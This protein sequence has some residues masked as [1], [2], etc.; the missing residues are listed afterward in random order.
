MAS[1]SGNSLALIKRSLRALAAGPSNDSIKLLS[2][3]D[4]GNPADID[5]LD[6]RMVSEVKVGKGGGAEIKLADRLGAIKL[7]LELEDKFKE[8]SD[9]NAF[10]SALA[11]T[12]PDPD[13]K[14]VLD[15]DEEPAP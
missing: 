5:A 12:A 1:P 13:S 6:L 7:L 8:K 10:F 14:E 11:H 4:S 9:A 15:E 3:L 2:I